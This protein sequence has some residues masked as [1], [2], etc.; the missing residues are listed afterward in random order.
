MTFLF[1]LPYTGANFAKHKFERRSILLSNVISLI[2]FGFSAILF[3]VYCWWY[4]F[5]VVAAAIPT[6]G[7]LSLLTLFMNGTNNSVAGRT[8]LSILIPIATISLSIYSKSLYYDSQ[9]ELDYF[10]FRFIILSSCI[11]PAIFF[12]FKERGRLIFTS[13][14]TLLVLML[15]DPLHNLF[16]VPY[17]HGDLNKSTYGFTNIIVF[18]SYGILC[19]GV[20]FLKWTSDKNE[21]RADGLIQELNHTN[22]QLVEKNSEIEAQNFEINAQ[23]EKLNINQQQLQEAYSLIEEHKNILQQQN[24]SLSDELIEKNKAL[25]ETN[26]ELIKHNNELRQF[27]YTVSHNLR[28]PV[29]SLLG[30]ITFLDEKRLTE[31]DAEI[32]GHIKLA[33]YQLDTIIKDLSKIIDIRNDIFQIR[34]KIN[35]IDE[36]AEVS[37]VL[38]KDFEKHQVELDLDLRSCENIYS[39]KPMV[40]SILYNLLSNAI[41]YRSAE[42]KPKITIT[43]TENATHFI[44]EVMD[45]G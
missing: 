24:Q 11:F 29:A 5:S 22:E 27:S 44:I 31:N 13:A 14:V 37:N 42:R 43:S 39:V 33:T 4:D 10:T 23:S 30:L 9:E 26:T 15:H 36:I 16:G 38:M 19:A 34:Q 8:W 35:L 28:A 45:N 20:L 12:S 32:F 3:V 7:I 6:I 25:T 17:H 1:K 40:H 41:K 18:V 21:A 2:L